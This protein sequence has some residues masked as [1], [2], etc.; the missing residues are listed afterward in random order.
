MTS[1]M[2]LPKR[3][4]LCLATCVLLPTV[5]QA[6]GQLNIYN[7]GNYTNPALIEKF[8]KTYDVAVTVTDYDSNDTALAKI[9]AGGHGYDIVVPTGPFIPVFIEQGLLLASNP[10][11]MENFAHVDPQWVDVPFDPGRVYTVPYLW[12][13][14]GMAVNTA[15][16]D[17]DINTAAIVF[18]TPAALKGKVN[19]VPEMSDVMFLAI[20]Y[21][22]GSQCTDDRALLGRV[23]DMLAEAKKDWLAMDYGTTEAYA[24]GDIGAGI[25]WNG[26]AMRARLENPAIAYGYPVTGYPIWMDNA[27]ILA[28]AQNVENAKLFLNFI[29]APENAAMMSDFARYANGITGSEAFMDPQM[30]TAPEVIPP[31]DLR[32]A[33]IVTEICPP[34]VQRLYAAIWTEL[35]K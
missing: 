26:A 15:L 28:D 2:I 34:D 11:Q 31:A 20:H 13:T 30:A 22:G 27:A 16:Y 3:S 33:G 10:N 5:A 17:G 4:A 18:D 7:W 6:E 29:M 23:R 32:A 19:V 25:N 9:R 24:T 1:S 14:V 21:L 12:G 8:A 35:Q